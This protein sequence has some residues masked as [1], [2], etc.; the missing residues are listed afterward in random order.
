[1]N[2]RVY[3]SREA[4]EQAKRERTLLTLLFMALGVSIGAVVALMFAPRRG[5]EL[6]S[7][8]THVLEGRVDSGRETT[9][10]LA[11]RLEGELNDFRKR[12]EERF[13]ELR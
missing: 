8:L 13:S 1:M 3:Y 5:E 6:R 11:K 4:E 7:G 12:V 9:A 10:A 2:E